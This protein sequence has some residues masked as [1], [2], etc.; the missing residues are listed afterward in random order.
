MSLEKM[1]FVKVIGQLDQLDDVIK[2]CHKDGNFQAEQAMQYVS[3]IKGFLP[4]NEENPYASYLQKLT[5]MGTASEI[6]FENA[7]DSS[8]DMDINDI[9]NYVNNMFSA[10]C[11]LYI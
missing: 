7:D 6:T 8:L 1:E 9:Y 11:V 3:T 10:N 4:L 5:D 2:C